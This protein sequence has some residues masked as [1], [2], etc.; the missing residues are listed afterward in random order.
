MSVPFDRQRLTTNYMLNALRD[1]A[2]I[3]SNVLVATHHTVVPV[4][5]LSSTILTALETLV[6]DEVKHDPEAV[7]KVLGASLLVLIEMGVS[8]IAAAGLQMQGVV[9]RDPADKH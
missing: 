4:G 1:H 3:E 7:D 2:E 9:E 8:A 6:T 5:P